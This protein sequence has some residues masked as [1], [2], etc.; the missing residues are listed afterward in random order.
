MKTMLR[1]GQQYLV[2]TIIL[3]TCILQGAFADHNPQYDTP[4]ILSAENM[5]QDDAINQAAEIIEEKFGVD[6]QNLLQSWNPEAKFVWNDLLN[7]DD[8]VWTVTFHME[9]PKVWQYEV[10]FSRNGELLWVKGWDTIYYKPDFNVLDDAKIVSPTQNDATEKQAIAVARLNLPEMSEYSANEANNLNVNAYFIY[11]EAFCMG[12]AP[13]WYIQFFDHETMVHEMLLS[14]NGEVMDSLPSAGMLFY[15][16]LLPQENIEDTLRI[17]FS[18][19]GF[20]EASVE[21]KAKL[22]NEWKPLVDAYLRDHPY[23]NKDNLLYAATDHVYSVPSD[24]HI[25]IEQATTIAKVTAIALGADEETFEKRSIEYFFDATDP[26]SP[27]WK[28]VIFYAKVPNEVL[29]ENHNLSNYRVIIDAETGTVK[30][31][32]EV[33]DNMRL[34]DWRF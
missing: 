18:T 17:C 2:I 25:S 30:D 28:L 13:V 8:S 19:S 7:A 5:Q 16:V 12:D 3:L 23:M 14:Y 22:Y 1:K 29:S 6:S 21:K 24:N 11:H 20:W 27:V 4:P 26:R 32:F 34:L 33:P 15:N 10:I 9:T 31:A